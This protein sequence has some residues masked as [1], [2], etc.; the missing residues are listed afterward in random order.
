MANIERIAN[1]IKSY[2]LLK[3]DPII[4]I[5]LKDLDVL[6][7]QFINK[8]IANPLNEEEIQ[9]SFLKKVEDLRSFIFN[10][11]N[12]T[13]TTKAFNFDNISVNLTEYIDLITSLKKNI[14][15]KISVIVPENISLKELKTHINTA[16]NIF[17]QIRNDIKIFMRNIIQSITFIDCQKSIY[18]N[19]NPINI[20]VFNNEL[21]LKE[22]INLLQSG[23]ND[24]TTFFSDNYLIRNL[25]EELY[26]KITKINDAIN[27]I[28]KFNNFLEKCIFYDQS[29]RYYTIISIDDIR[30]YLDKLN[31]TNTFVLTEHAF[32][33]K[34]SKAIFN[35]IIKNNKCIQLQEGTISLSFF[36]LFF[37]FFT[38][39]LDNTM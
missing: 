2:L 4:H 26:T 37:S 35:E 38:Q 3:D 8:A 9:T 12:E 29:Y 14:K 19:I 32:L 11:D 5:F 20:E 15:S 27:D 34:I 30:F 10:V 28:N 17:K 16:D 6:K 25:E 24:I 22:T 33:F 36:T 31:S 7:K 39:I 18:T 21:S 13:V 23:G 1:K